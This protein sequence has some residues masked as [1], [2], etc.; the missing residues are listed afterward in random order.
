VALCGDGGDEAFAGYNHFRV[1]HQA[2][3]ARTGA[4]GSTKNWLCHAGAGLLPRRMRRQVR[5]KL[6]PW[7]LAISFPDPWQLWLA[8]RCVFDPNEASLL[9]GTRLDLPSGGDFR[10]AEASFYD[11]EHYLRGDLLVKMDRASMGV[12]LEV[13][14]PFLDDDLVRYCSLLPLEWRISSDGL[15]KRILR[16]AYRQLLPPHLWERPKQGF[17]I[18][19]RRWL[20]EGA[21]AGSVKRLLD[22]PLSPLW[23]VLEK[24]A[25]L[26][27]LRLFLRGAGNEQKVWSLI[28]LEYWLKN[29]FGFS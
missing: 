7:R 22:E 20:R 17:Q 14:A 23:D 19:V 6:A 25:A 27:E 13:R 16:D 26:P 10:E 2:L 15:G 11:Y 21:M 5:E 8:L 28:A 29:S 18:P 24:S 9:A 1:F 3:H 12:A 4:L